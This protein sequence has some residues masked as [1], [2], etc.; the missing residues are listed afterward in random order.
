ML[1]S[2]AAALMLAATAVA[3]EFEV[4]IHYEVLPI[5]VATATPGKIEV[6]EIF[7]YGCGACFRFDPVVEAWRA[8]LPPDVAFRRIPAMFR[9]EWAILGQAFYTA[10]ALGVSEQLHGALFDA[11]HL[12]GVDFR[13]PQVLAGIFRD[14]AGVDEAD[15]D[16]TFNSFGV[17]SKTQQADA[18]GR[19]YRLSGVPTLVV[20]GRYRIYGGSI[21]ASTTGML[22]VVDYLVAKVREEAAP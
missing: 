7:S 21:D 20:D 4:G 3:D 15:F 2:A 9:Q 22:A 10:E 14:A 5:P 12:R 6:V 8:K 18:N 19:M 16:R 11:I 1:L 13:S 17:R